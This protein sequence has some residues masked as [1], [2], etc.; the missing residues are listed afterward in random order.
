MTKKEKFNKSQL[1]MLLQIKFRKVS[2]E[3]IKE[4]ILHLSDY[5]RL[6]TETIVIMYIY[7]KRLMENSKM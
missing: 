7:I 1:R 4:Y 2:V 6:N 5:L 3:N